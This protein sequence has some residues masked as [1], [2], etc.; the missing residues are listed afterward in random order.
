MLRHPAHGALAHRELDRQAVGAPLV[1]EDERAHDA[2]ARLVHDPH[3]HPWAS[4]KPRGRRHDV[5]EHLVRIEGRRHEAID[6]VECL[7]PL[8]VVARLAVQARVPDRDGGVVRQ[9]H[10]DRFV[11]VGEAVRRAVVDVQQPLDAAVDDDR[12]RH[13]RDEAFGLHHARVALLDVRIFEVTRGAE[14]LARGE[15][16]AAHALPGLDAERVHRGA[17]L[18]G[19]R[20]R[21]H[22]VGAGLAQEDARHVAAAEIARADGHTLEHGREI[23][24]GVDG[25]RDFREHLRFTPAAIGL[26]V[27][28]GVADGHGG[29]GDEALEQLVLVRPQ[30]NGPRPV[31]VT[32]A[33]RR[34]CPSRAARA[35]GSPVL[36]H[37]VTAAH[38]RVGREDVGDVE[39]GAARGDRAPR[40]LR[41][42]GHA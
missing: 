37:P 8:R 11:L 40:P 35:C 3:R 28:T 13:G 19:G 21:H 25:A 6:L 41:R 18:A 2:P 12:H 5:P 36:A 24:R 16:D 23:E 1:A 15:H 26:S 17:A 32:T 29:L 22:R 34:R 9:P 33:G 30:P 20:A 4:K 14:R 10:E 27:Q 38:R 42:S 39:R 31:S 7:Q